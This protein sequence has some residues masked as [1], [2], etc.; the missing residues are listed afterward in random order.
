MTAGRA[1]NAPYR[2]S[3]RV[4]RRTLTSLVGA[5][6][7][8]VCVAWGSTIYLHTRRLPWSSHRYAVGVESSHNG[9]WVVTSDRTRLYTRL[10]LRRF[11]S[12]EFANDYVRVVKDGWQDNPFLSPDVAGHYERPA[13]CEYPSLIL[14]GSTVGAASLT[15]FS[16]EAAG[17]PFVCFSARS[18]EGARNLPNTPWHKGFL[19]FAG[20]YVPAHPHWPGLIGN[21]LFY[22]T[23]LT[24][25]IWLPEIASRSWRRRHTRCVRCGYSLRGLIDG[26]LCPECGQ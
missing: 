1:H 15:H 9:T 3:K 12:V 17:W 11:E 18:L 5:L 2:R 10:W 22:A 7:C 19:R 16:E 21:V 25:L 13:W 23:A 6:A 14:N 8:T 20:H 4:I 26:T 24:G